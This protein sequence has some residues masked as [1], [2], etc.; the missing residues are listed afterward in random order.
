[1][2]DISPMRRGGVDDSLPEWSGPPLGRSKRGAR[3]RSGIDLEMGPSSRVRSRARTR[4]A[5]RGQGR[6]EQEEGD[7]SSM[8]MMAGCCCMVVVFLVVG[9]VFIASQRGRQSNTQGYQQQQ[10][11]NP[12]YMTPTQP[13]QPSPG[14]EEYAEDSPDLTDVPETAPVV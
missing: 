3:A 11:Y 1:M 9:G 14:V 12:N 5:R 6:P 8:L 4:R 13:S 10:Q 2:G 7:N